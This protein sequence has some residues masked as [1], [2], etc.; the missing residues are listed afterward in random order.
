MKWP[1]V[2]LLVTPFLQFAAAQSADS[3]FVFFNKGV[4]EKNGRLFL[5]AFHDFQKS[6]HYDSNNID[7]QR[8]LGLT[9]FELRKYDDAIAA[10][11]KVETLKKND[12]TAITKLAYLY[13]WTRQ[14]A[15]AETYGQRARELKE[16]GNWS[17]MIGKSYYEQEDY[18][19]A[20]PYLRLAFLEDSSNAEIPY[21]IARGYVDMDNYRPAI[22][23][24]L[25]AIRLDTTN[26]RWVYECAL[27]CATIY[28]D[29]SA[30]QYYE[31]AAARGYKKDNDYYENLSDSYI[32]SGQLQK[33]L[34][35][36]LMVLQKKPADLELLYNVADACYRL[37]RY[38]DAIDYWDQILEYDKQNAKALYMIGMSYQKK[39][40]TDKGRQLCDRAIEIDPSLKYLKQEKRIQ[41]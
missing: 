3:S 5:V 41:L 29:K 17:F 9:A 20:F 19:Q 35:L 32:A 12:D 27:T 26:A 37:G 28:D 39:G 2:F 10:F 1:F 40:D 14:W 25:R 11:L 31:L 16:R 18:G 30:I 34:D 13:F 6:L 7:A 38:K 36:M 21:L 8:E 4:Q 33:G 24:F 22:P 23:Y 15:Q